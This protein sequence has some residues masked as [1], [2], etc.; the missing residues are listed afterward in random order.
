MTAD[1]RR[2]LRRQLTKTE[3]DRSLLLEHI[4]ADLALFVTLPAWRN[5]RAEGKRQMLGLRARLAD[6]RRQ[7]ELAADGLDGLV[8]PIVELL[9]SLADEQ[10]RA[11]LSTHDLDAASAVA[12]RLEQARLHLALETGAAARPF[13]AALEEADRLRGRD[14]GFDAT[15]RSLRQDA[16]SEADASVLRAAIAGLQQGL[17]GVASQLNRLGELTQPDA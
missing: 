15:V 10:T 14:D 12:H 9:A 8:T 3:V 11:H 1:L 16:L 13:A 4:D 7:M 17:Q 5:V 6:T 2:A